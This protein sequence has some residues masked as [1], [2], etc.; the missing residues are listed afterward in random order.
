M[1]AQLMG[2]GIIAFALVV[3]YG[4]WQRREWGRIFGI[5]FCCVVLFIFVGMR[6]LQPFLVPEIRVS[7][8]W[9][10]VLMG[11]LSVA[12]LVGLSCTRFAK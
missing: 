11:F 1:H 12:C 7:F 2:L 4:L 8:E 9:D 10:A 5:S 6:L 3:A